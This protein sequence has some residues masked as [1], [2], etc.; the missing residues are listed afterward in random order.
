MPDVLVI[1]SGTQATSAFFVTRPYGLAFQVPS[2]APSSEVR[3]Q[4]AAS[5]GAGVSGDFW[6]DLQRFDGTGI[7]YSVYSGAG[8]AMGY[9]PFPPPTSFLRVT[10]TA[11]QT[12]ART[13]QIFSV[14]GY[15]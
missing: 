12:N 7:P 9:L 6:G 15:T 14:L 1:G 11:S 10:V 8:P 3:L 2:L 5:S 4:F 13:L